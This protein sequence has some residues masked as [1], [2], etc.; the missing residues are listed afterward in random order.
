MGHTKIIFLTTVNVK[1]YNARDA[2]MISQGQFIMKSTTNDLRLYI[3]WI[4]YQRQLKAYQSWYVSSVWLEQTCVYV[5][6]LQVLHEHM[7]ERE[8]ELLNLNLYIFLFKLYK[9]S[10]IQSFTCSNPCF[11]FPYVA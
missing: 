2:N 10:Q 7:N 9:T 11:A 1:R 5:E 6:R 4:I 8:T 3:T